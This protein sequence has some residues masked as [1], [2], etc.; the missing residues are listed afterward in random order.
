[1]KTFEHGGDVTAF[2]KDCKCNVSE[3][4]DLSSNINIVK[5]QVNINFNRLN[6]APYPNYDALYASIASHYHVNTEEI[7]L[8]NGA[9]SAIFSLFRLLKE[10]HKELPLHCTLYSPAYL[11]YKKA[12]TLFGYKIININRYKNIMQEV[13]AESLIVFVNPATP[14]GISYNIEK[15]LNRWIAKKCTILIDE[16]FLEFTDTPSMSHHI[17]NYDKLYI[18]KSM[19]KFYGAAG[20]RIGVLLSNIKNITLLKTYEPNWKISALDSYYIQKVLKDKTLKK[21]TKRQLEE[22]KIKLLSMF[23]HCTYV[24]KIYPSQANYLLLKL[25]NIN[26]IDFQTLLAKEKILIRN[27]TNFEGLDEF[28][29]RIAIKDN[30]SITALKK[31]LYA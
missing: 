29:V 10:R 16:S 20:I 9:S 17:K 14:D 15:L 7:E 5:P 23:N 1:M 18:L 12:A 22:T 13:E 31:A 11:E 30:T 4:I 24:E 25:K 28:H 3:I 26:A 27:C 19:T 21:R 6:I 8:F 2:A